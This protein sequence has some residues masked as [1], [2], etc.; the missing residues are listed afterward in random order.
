MV[1]ASD[2]AWHWARANSSLEM[3]VIFWLRRCL[4]GSCWCC[5]E[6]A[7]SRRAVSRRNAGSRPSADDDARAPRSPGGGI[8]TTLSFSPLCCTTSTR[9]YAHFFPSFRSGRLCRPQSSLFR[10][11]FPGNSVAACGFSLSSP[12][13]TNPRVHTMGEQS[14]GVGTGGRLGDVVVIVA[15]VAALTA[16]LLT[17]V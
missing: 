2:R 1:G 15:G 13:S 8:N 6:R 12:P 17:V 16:T 14:N 11:T 4:A 7:R 10:E 3:V 9:S 5:R